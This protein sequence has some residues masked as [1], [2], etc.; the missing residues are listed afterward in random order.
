[1]SLRPDDDHRRSSAA[2]EMSGTSPGA[3]LAHVG[4]STMLVLSFLALIPGFL[5]AFVLGAALALALLV[6]MLAIA[7]V[8][9]LLLLPILAVRRLTRHYSSGNVRRNSSPEREG[10]RTPTDEIVDSLS[11]VAGDP[12]LRSAM[13]K[14]IQEI[15][16]LPQTLPPPPLSTKRNSDWDHKR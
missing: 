10:F 1:M 4:G 6:P 12:A 2:R 14:Q 11:L 3:A 16:S 15:R 7:A 5:P 8:S 9:S 13:N